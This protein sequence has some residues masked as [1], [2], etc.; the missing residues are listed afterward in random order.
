MVI[1]PL[2]THIGLNQLKNLMVQTFCRCPQ[3]FWVWVLGE[4][5]HL[6]TNWT[7]NLFISDLE[8]VFGPSH[9][10]PMRW[11]AC[12]VWCS[13]YNFPS[14]CQVV[15]QFNHNW[16]CNFARSVFLGFSFIIALFDLV[17]EEILK[18]CC[19][20]CVIIL[21]GYLVISLWNSCISN[22]GFG[23]AHNLLHTIQFG[24]CPSE[25]LRN[26]F[27]DELFSLF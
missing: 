10:C 19:T 16:G 6:I 7:G 5:P 8:S 17:V 13:W 20:S 27:S 2:R 18:S 23:L 12:L 11:N 25:K 3:V 24:A 9:G 15:F 14:P 1:T 26:V 22:F 4:E 21:L